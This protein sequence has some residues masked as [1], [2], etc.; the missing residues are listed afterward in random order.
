MTIYH[1]DPYR[2][3]VNV[4]FFL[5]HEISPTSGDKESINGNTTC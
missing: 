2:S 5:T 1:L 3:R 4:C